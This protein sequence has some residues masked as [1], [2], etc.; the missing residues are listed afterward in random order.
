HLRDVTTMIE[1]LGTLGVEVVV[2]ERMNVEIHA[3]TIN[4]F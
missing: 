1:L 3:N 4:C 2:D